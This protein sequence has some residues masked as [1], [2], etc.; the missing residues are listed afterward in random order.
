[1]GR[2]LTT[3][4]GAGAG[5]LRLDEGVTDAGPDRCGAVLADHLGD[6]STRDGVV[7]D[8]HVALAGHPRPADLSGG[9]ET[10]DRTR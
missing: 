2:V 1:M 9:H 4:D 5:H 8:G 7:H 10:G 3:E 6:R